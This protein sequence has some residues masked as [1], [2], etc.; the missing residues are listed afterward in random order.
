MKTTLASALIIVS[1]F[2]GASTAAAQQQEPGRDFNEASTVIERQLEESLSELSALRERLVEEKLPLSRTLRELEAELTQVRQEFQQTSRTLDGRTLDLSNLRNEIE[3][4]RE[5]ATYLSNLFGEYIRNFETRLHISEIQRYRDPIEA[6]RL[7]PENDSL[8]DE[9]V[10]DAQVTLIGT[11]LERLHNLVGGTRFKGSAV[12]PG[13]LVKEGEF[14]L[15]GP[16]A[17]FK[18]ADGG[19]VGTAEQRLGSLEPTIIPFGNPEDAEA[20]ADLVSNQQ[21]H[22][23]FDPTLGNAHKVESTHDSL[24]THIQKGGPVMVPIFVLAGAAMLV[25]LVKW[26][27]LAFLGTPSEKRFRKLLDAVASRDKPLAVKRAKALRGPVG[28]MLA[29]GAEHLDEPRELIEEVM[30]ENLLST[31]LKL[32]RFLPFIAISAAAAPLLGLLGTVTGIMNTFALITVFGTGD[33]KTLS[34]GI[35][36]ALITTEFGLIVAIPSLLLH[37]FLSRKARGVVNQM[38]KCGVRFINQV[39]KAAKPAV[40]QAA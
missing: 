23:P 36:E 17:I 25:A 10:F 29:Y 9:E 37:A 34:S 40:E 39:T 33:V 35:S 30:Y 6:A 12:D 20:A 7:A 1:S 14:V 31:R 3:S 22:F 38:E 19:V 2:L 11:S 28:S 24:W 15:V 5:E 27:G 26:L 32:Q 13:G 16:M 4:R 21:G 8:S 18:A